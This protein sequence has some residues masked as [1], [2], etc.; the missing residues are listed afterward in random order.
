MSDQE[1]EAI[2]KEI[3]SSVLDVGSAN[4]LTVGVQVLFKEAIFDAG[5]T[6]D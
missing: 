2:E 3:Q 5:I 6:N 4:S 1:A